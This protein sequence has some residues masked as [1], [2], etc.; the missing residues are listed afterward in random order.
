MT[1][2]YSAELIRRCQARQM[3]TATTEAAAALGLAIDAG[4]ISLSQVLDMVHSCS[5]TDELGSMLLMLAA[6]VPAPAG[7]A[8]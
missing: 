5:S 7:G 1:S 2:H 8:E 6:T 4:L 3:G